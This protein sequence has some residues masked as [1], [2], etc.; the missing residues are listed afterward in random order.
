MSAGPVYAGIGFRS[1][2]TEGEIADLVRASMARA[3]LY[4]SRL[5]ALAVPAFKTGHEAATA[6]AD[7]FGVTLTAIDEPALADAAP[8]CQTQSEI[9]LR[10]RGLPSVAEC[11]ALAAAGPGSR[12]LAPRI[13]GASATCA[14][15]VRN[16]GGQ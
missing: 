16:G 3:G 13:K 4:D 11:A 12:L 14:L 7:T 10:E 1:G 5:C 9:S 2:A 8:R 6:A 15:A